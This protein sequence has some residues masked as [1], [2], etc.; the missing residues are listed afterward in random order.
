MKLFIPGINNE[1]LIW[2][3]EETQ[4]MRLS[5]WANIFGNF[6]VS[7]SYK[8]DQ[9]VH[10]FSKHRSILECMETERGI[11]FL[12]RANHRQL[13]PIEIVLDLDDNPTIEQFNKI[14]DF[15]DMS[16]DIYYGYFTGSK[17]YHIHIFSYD[18]CI[19]RNRR[20]IRLALINHF[21]ADSL[22]ISEKVMIAMENQPHWKT[23]NTKRLLRNGRHS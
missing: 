10:H 2:R 9:G 20:E 17:G 18:L 22:K 21:K 6:K 19:E 16:Q 11:N 15:L 23:G 8:D 12:E 3:K 1:D 13:L 4:Q 14:C 7:Y 5:R